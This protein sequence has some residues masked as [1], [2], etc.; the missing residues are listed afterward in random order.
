MGHGG[1]VDL[2]LGT[3]GNRFD[4]GAPAGPRFIVGSSLVPA[5]PVVIRGVTAV[6]QDTSDVSIGGHRG[7]LIE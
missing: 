1:V 2:E 4:P 5:D 6:A 7:Q 3:G